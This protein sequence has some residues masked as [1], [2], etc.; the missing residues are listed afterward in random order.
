MDDDVRQAFE[1]ID[2]RFERVDARF[3][4]VLEL[5]REMTGQLNGKLG[6]VLDQLA[7]NRADIENAQGHMV[8]GLE[9]NL[10]LGRRLTRLEEEVRRLRG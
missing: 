1:R 10:T 9:S 8:F 5:L 2:A 3:D 6:E 7:A 4:A